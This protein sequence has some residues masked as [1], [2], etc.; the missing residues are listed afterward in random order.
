MR[1]D[2]LRVA[3]LFGWLG[4]SG[5]GWGDEAEFATGDSAAILS[6]KGSSP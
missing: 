1:K 2:A 6:L 4:L 3:L 5:L